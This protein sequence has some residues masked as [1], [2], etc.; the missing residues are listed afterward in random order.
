MAPRQFAASRRAHRTISSG[1]SGYWEASLVELSNRT[2]SEVAFFSAL[3]LVALCS[4]V[5]T[6]DPKYSPVKRFCEK[7]ATH[8]LGIAMKSRLS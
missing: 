3:D 8:C 5:S 4:T 1:S 6:L 7:C 2:P